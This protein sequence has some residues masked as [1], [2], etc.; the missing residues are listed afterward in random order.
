MF[1]SYSRL[2]FAE[3]AKAAI[4]RTR[5]EA[6]RELIRTTQ[7]H[8]REIGGLQRSL[9]AAS[10]TS[11]ANQASAPG[12][13]RTTL[14]LRTTAPVPL[15]LSG[16]ARALVVSTSAS[17]NHADKRT[18]SRGQLRVGGAL[19]PHRIQFMRAVPSVV[20]QSPQSRRWAQPPGPRLGFAPALRPDGPTRPDRRPPANRHWPCP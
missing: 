7:E 17:I 14:A 4:S 18:V 13:S 19:R 1:E 3:K 16:F 11:V 9:I 2:V 15:P 12:R 6:E 10:V 8:F 5:A 20:P